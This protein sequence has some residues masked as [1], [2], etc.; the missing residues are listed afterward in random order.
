MYLTE[1][2]VR[3]T[4]EIFL[5]FFRG[6]IDWAG[7][8]VGLIAVKQQPGMILRAV[9]LLDRVAKPFVDP[10]CF[11]PLPYP[12]LV[13]IQHPIY[14]TEPYQRCRGPMATPS[15]RLKPEGANGVQTVWKG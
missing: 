10:Q 6:E 1:S 7:C 12:F 14:I 11:S 3:L 15:A 5:T 4:K 8:G 13:G 9:R 2:S